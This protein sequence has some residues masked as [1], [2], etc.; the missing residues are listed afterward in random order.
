[1]KKCD[2]CLKNNEPD[3][4]QKYIDACHNKCPENLCTVCWY[5][6]GRYIVLGSQYEDKSKE[7]KP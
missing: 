5:A 3:V 4:D 2:K 1:M 6:Y 7:A